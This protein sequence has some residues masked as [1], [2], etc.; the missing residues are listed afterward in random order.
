[1]LDFDA[2]VLGPIYSTFGSPAV[3]TIGPITHEIVV[4]DFTKGISVED[5][6]GV[7]IQTIRPAV[8]V[9]R[10]TLTALSVELDDLPDYSLTLNGAVW[11]IKTLIEGDVEVRLILMQS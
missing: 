6:S 11:T 10:Q 4:V 8:D 7:G 9:R 2:L 5:E 3:L 1:M